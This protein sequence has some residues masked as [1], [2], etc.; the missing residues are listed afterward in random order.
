MFLDIMHH[1]VLYKTVFWRL[2]MSPS[3][4]ELTQLG[5]IN[6]ASPYLPTPTQGKVY[7]PRTGQM[8]F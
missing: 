1:P 2:F 6:G 7:K 4:L 8:F 5:P 3:S